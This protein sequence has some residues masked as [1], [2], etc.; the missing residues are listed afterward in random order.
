MVNDNDYF[1]FLAKRIGPVLIKYCTSESFPMDDLEAKKGTYNVEIRARYGTE[2][3][4]P[5]Y[6]EETIQEKKGSSKGDE[7]MKVIDQKLALYIPE[8][9][10]VGGPGKEMVEDLKDHFLTVK[11]GELKVILITET[12][13][14]RREKTV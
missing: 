8:S 13:E 7:S 4:F 2:E 6:I 1:R 11:E 10:W 3:E 9:F 14:F 5:I 12:Q